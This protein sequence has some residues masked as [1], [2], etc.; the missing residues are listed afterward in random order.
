MYFEVNGGY[1]NFV[2]LFRHPFLRTTS[3]DAIWFTRTVSISSSEALLCMTEMVIYKFL[4]WKSEVH[5]KKAYHPNLAKNLKARIF[6]IPSSSLDLYVGCCTVF[7]GIST[8]NANCA[9]LICPVI[10]EHT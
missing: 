8:R 6:R 10:P 7:G 9:S 2:R 5:Q 1:K 3:F 4:E